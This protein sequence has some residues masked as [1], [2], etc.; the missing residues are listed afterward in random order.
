[1]KSTRCSF[2][3]GTV[4]NAR[5]DGNANAPEWHRERARMDS[6]AREA[7]RARGAEGG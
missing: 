6:R 2:Q 4:L 5:A 7:K 1:M 3:R